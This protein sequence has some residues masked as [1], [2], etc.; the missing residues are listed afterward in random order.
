MSLKNSTPQKTAKK[1]TRMSQR[2]LTLYG[3]L[4]DLRMIAKLRS[5]AQRV[6]D[7][8]ATKYFLLEVVLG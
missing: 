6:A 1:R 5:D 8:D 7:D 3:Y 2:Q 4:K